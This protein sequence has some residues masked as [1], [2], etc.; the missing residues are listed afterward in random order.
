MVYLAGDNNVAV[1]GIFDIDEM[2]AAGID[3]KVQVVVQ[4]E[5]SPAQ[6]AQYSCGAEC[7]HR[8]NFNT[9]RYWVT[10]AGTE[11]N[12]PNGDAE[13]IGNVNMTD[14]AQLR[15]FI[16]WGKQTYP[17]KKFMVVL[18]NH[19]GGDL[20]LLQDETSPG[21]SL[22]SLDGLKAGLTGVGPIDVVDFDMCLIG[23]YETWA[24]LDGL[25]Q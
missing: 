5:L 1:N 24:K 20:G 6:L 14:Q 23:G 3:P 18:W 10:G 8:P 7:F 16:N 21:S 25:T 4:G 15:A 11:S 12:G 9:F 19:G 22:M 17:A 2:E 13:D